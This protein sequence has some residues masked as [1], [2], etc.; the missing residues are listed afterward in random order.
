MCACC[1]APITAAFARAQALEGTVAPL[2]DELA[3][4]ELVAAAWSGLDA[5]RVWDVHAHLLGTGDSG[6][7][8]YVNPRSTSLLHPVEYVR[9]S[10][11]LKAAGVET[12]TEVDRRYVERLR[13]L[14][15][16]MA[17]GYK[18][19]LFAFDAAVGDDGQEL[20]DQSTF[21]TPNAYAAAVARRHP[22]HF[23]WVASVHPYRVDAIERLNRA[24]AD[25]ARAI[26]WLP[27]AM[28]IDPASK[29]CDEFYARLKALGLP[30]IVH[31]G[32]EAAAPGAGHAEYNN[33]LRLRRAL[34]AGVRVIMAHAATLG[35]ARDTERGSEPK[36]P[37]F[38]L[39]ARLMDDASYRHN[40][41]GDISAVFQRNRTLEAMRTLLRREDWHARLLQGSDYPLP[42]VRFLYSLDEL[43]EAGL[44]EQ[45]A[46]GVLRKIRRHNPLLFEFVLKRTV[47]DGKQRLARDVF[48]T[49][50]RFARAAV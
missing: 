34:E 35:H 27:S 28:N 1:V 7:G 21:A 41:L 4:H 29:R 2:P 12:E 20:L 19:L 6:G 48:H 43:A 15:A 42:G 17:P 30:L 9:R 45:R 16:A 38:E 33:P 14:A 18:L 49:R 50:D 47:A 25:G 36:V 39:F 10:V 11:M 22:E 13:G 5:A 44:I 31:C 32:E 37:A 46:V 23:E 26:K 24:A 40:L 8:A 3:R